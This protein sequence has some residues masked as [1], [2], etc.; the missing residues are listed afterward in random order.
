MPSHA[1]LPTRLDPFDLFILTEEAVATAAI[2][3]RHCCLVNHRSVA[4]IISNKDTRYELDSIVGEERFSIELD[5]NNQVWYELL[6]FSK[7]AHFLSFI[8]YHCIIFF[9]YDIV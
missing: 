6:S 8:G 5:E 1:G 9:C 7:P 4:I 2:V 3:V